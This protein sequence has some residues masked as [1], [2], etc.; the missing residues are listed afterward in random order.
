MADKVALLDTL[1]ARDA[2]DRLAAALPPAAASRVIRWAC[3]A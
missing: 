2:L 1:D 3:S